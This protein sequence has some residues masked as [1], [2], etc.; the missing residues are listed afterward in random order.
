LEW[1]REEPLEEV[2]NTAAKLNCLAKD[3]SLCYLEWRCD[4][5][6]DEPCKVKEGGVR[7]WILE[8]S[9]DVTYLAIID[10]KHVMG[11]VISLETKRICGE[12]VT[13]LKVCPGGSVA[14]TAI[15]G[16]WVGMRERRRPISL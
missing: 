4:G 9:W 6:W 10:G 2:M 1:L 12:S 15:Q 5:R 3:K 8:N 16:T 7:D 14:L 13:T 11:V